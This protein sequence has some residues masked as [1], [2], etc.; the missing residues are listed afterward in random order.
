MIHYMYLPDWIKS[1]IYLELI[2]QSSRISSVLSLCD[3]ERS[4]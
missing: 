2:W 3:Y 4:C 1:V